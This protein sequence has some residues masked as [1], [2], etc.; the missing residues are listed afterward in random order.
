MKTFCFTGKEVG[1]SKKIIKIL[2]DEDKRM[3]IDQLTL[4]YIRNI[5]EKLVPY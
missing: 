4:N 5:P 1:I 2:Q 3:K